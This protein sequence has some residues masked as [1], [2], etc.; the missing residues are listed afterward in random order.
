MRLMNGDVRY[1]VRIRHAG[2]AR[3]DHRGRE[4]AGDVVQVRAAAV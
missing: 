3:F 1:L 4:L 2:R